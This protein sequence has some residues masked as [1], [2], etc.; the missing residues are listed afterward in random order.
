M[1]ASHTLTAKIIHWSFILLYAY[2]IFK[3]LDDISELENSELLI[4]E[5]FFASV[6][7]IIVLIRYFY[8]RRFETF[9][10]IREP[11]PSAHKYLA[12]TIHVSIYLCLIVL[13]LTGL[14]IAGLFTRGITDGAIQDLLLEIHGFSADLSYVL[15]AIHIGAAIYSR[16]KGE[17]VWTSMVPIWKEDKSVTNKTIIKVKNIENNFF[18]KVEDFF[19]TQK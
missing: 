16:V 3:Q 7:L 10:G 11:V 6:F 4:F 14:L 13:P 1:M 9:L 17:G 8:M 5:V 19:S 12:K 18:E 15:I 2:G